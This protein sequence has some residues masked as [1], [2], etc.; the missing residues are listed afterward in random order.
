MQGAE[1]KL[2]EGLQKLGKEMREGPK[3]PTGGLAGLPSTRVLTGRERC[4]LAQNGAP[5][6]GPAAQALCKGKGFQGGKSIDTQ[7][8]RAC[9]PRV[10][11]SG[12]APTETECPTEM[13]VVRAMCQ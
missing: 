3:E 1:D 9:S 7:T 12:R 8:E 5:D 2:G 11:L 13:F 10:L 6:C 4:A